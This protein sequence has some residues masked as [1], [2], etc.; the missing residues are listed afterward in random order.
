[1]SG[2]HISSVD[3]T[4]NGPV[5][6][7]PAAFFNGLHVV[8]LQSVIRRQLLFAP[9]DTVDTLLVG[10]TMRR[11][12]AQR[13]F[14]DAKILATR[15][16]PSG[17]VALT[18]ST[19]D[20]WT[21]RPRAQLRTGSQLSLG[22]EDRNFLGTGKSVSLTREYTMRGNGAAFAFSDPFFFGP[23]VSASGRLANL[24][25]G[26]T[27]R[28]G[29]RKHD[30]SVFDD[31]KA[32]GNLSRLS[33]GDTIVGERA[34]HTITAMTMVGRRIGGGLGG[35]TLLLIG[36]EFDSAASI[37]PS[38]RAVGPDL[39]HTR[40]FAGID[41]GLQRRTAQFDSASW[42]VPG[43]GFIDIPLGLEGEGVVAT[44][45]ERGLSRAAMKLDAWMGRVWMPHRGSILMV[46]GW[47]SSYFGSGMDRNRITRGAVSFYD[48]AARGMWAARVTAEQ[49]LEVDP[50]R[51]GL[52][53]MAVADRTTP[54]VRHWAARGGKSVAASLG[55]D[56]HLFH[57]GGASVVNVGGFLAG[58][59][60][61]EV[62]DVPDQSL[63]VGVVGARLRVLSA[64]GTVSSV[65]L[66]VGFPVV[67][68]EI[69]SPK[70]Y[71]VLTYGTLFD[72]SRQRD[73]R[74]T[75]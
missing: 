36:A 32:E 21:L 68:S 41:V 1:M 20:T 47:A 19:V 24:A 16:D 55:R 4:S 34:L 63:R 64:N 28:F 40:S 69:L 39:A 61:W 50:D 48:A 27:L 59:Y 42:I 12:R 43:R 57:A 17:G 26:H 23:H 66:D 33:F 14:T 70:P 49:L 7:G 75:F 9:G 53:L 60:R 29:V 15:C 2:V 67:R 11:L 30:Y 13:L 38:K 5:L 8:S 71:V 58:S 6:P 62:M 3:I 45:Y 25:G 51:R 37:S 52:S 74:R 72:V 65:R 10:E 35:S 31:W 18:V 73:G 56:V 22:V 46:D 44:G 54:V